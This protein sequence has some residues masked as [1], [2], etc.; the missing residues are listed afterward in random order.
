MHYKKVKK[1]TSGTQLTVKT[2]RLKQK[3][4]CGEVMGVSKS[5]KAKK[6][7]QHQ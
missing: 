1:M 3:L 7:A 2:A 4:I 6:T 5:L